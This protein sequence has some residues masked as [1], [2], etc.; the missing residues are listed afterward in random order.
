MPENL[1][2]LIL[3]LNEQENIADCIRSVEDL[4]GEIVVLDSFSTDRTVE[5]ASGL[6]ATIQ[7]RKFDNYTA[8][9][10]AGLELLRNEW[11]LILDA[12]ER[13]TDSLRNEIRSLNEKHSSAEGYWI[14]RETFFQGKLVRCWSSGKVLRLFRRDRGRYADGKLVHEEL[15]LNGHAGTLV[16]PMEHHTFRSFA[17]Y[18]PKI[19]AYTTLAAREAYQQGKRSSVIGLLIYPAARFIKTYFVNGGIFD[20]MPGLII[21]WLSVCSTYLKFAKLWELEKRRP[22]L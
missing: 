21:A 22:K 11:V 7:Q 13:L 19:D 17:Q 16:E 6:G 15:V 1:S 20:G 2:V 18:L 10:N 3:T 9:K 12:D 5:I 8:Q 14:R 4:A